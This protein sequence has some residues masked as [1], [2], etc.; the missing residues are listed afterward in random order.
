M[1]TTPP[2]Q[3]D[4]PTVFPAATFYSQLGVI[5]SIF[6]PPPPPCVSTLAGK[7]DNKLIPSHVVFILCFVRWT[8][9]TIIPGILLAAVSADHVSSCPLMRINGYL[10]QW[11]G[12]L[13]QY[14][15]SDH[16]RVPAQTCKRCLT[17]VQCML[18]EVVFSLQ[19]KST[20]A[21][22]HNGFLK[23]ESILYSQC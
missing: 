23:C 2:G 21:L 8:S 4:N 17:N 20:S 3:R 16:S 15:T 18:R 1:C 5:N 7:N 9:L 6:T 14:D 13:R 19:K 22:C 11:L 12:W 10:R